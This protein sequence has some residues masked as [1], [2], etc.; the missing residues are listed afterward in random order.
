MRPDSQA[1]ERSRFP[2]SSTA[3]ADKTCPEEGLGHA[4]LLPQ[5]EARS[6]IRPLASCPS[7]SVSLAATG[8]VCLWSWLLTRVAG[9]SEGAG[10]GGARSGVCGCVVHVFYNSPALHVSA[11][12]AAALYLSVCSL[13]LSAE[14]AL[15]L[16]SLSLLSLSLS[17]PLSL[18][19]AVR[20][21]LLLLLLLLLCSRSLFARSHS[22]YT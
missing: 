12:T 5:R 22:L 18:S 13:Y 21:S 15:S 11:A 14:S 6:R 2:E 3:G 16:S 10:W 1:G 4:S 17:L 19:L 20:L 9:D 8:S 7:E